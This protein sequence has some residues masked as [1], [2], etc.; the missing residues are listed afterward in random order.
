MQQRKQHTSAHTQ[1][2]LPH[3]LSEKHQQFDYGAK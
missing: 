1:N 3:K 2:Q